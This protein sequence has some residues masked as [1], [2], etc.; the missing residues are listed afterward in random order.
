MTFN[1]YLTAV[2]PVEIFHTK[3]SANAFGGVAR[4]LNI[5]NH[6]FNPTA[7]GVQ[8]AY[9]L[10]NPLSTA[11]KLLED[12]QAHFIEF[13][14]EDG[15]DGVVLYKQFINFLENY[16]KVCTDNQDSNVKVSKV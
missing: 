9:E 5:Y 13:L 2:K 4:E 3:V 15:S 8:W 6:I 12:D 10:I 1:V 14:S 7:V 11:L 16:I